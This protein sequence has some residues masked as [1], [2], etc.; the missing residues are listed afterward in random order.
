MESI[1]PQIKCFD[2]KQTFYRNEKDIMEEMLRRPNVDLEI[3][4]VKCNIRRC[5]QSYCGYIIDKDFTKGINYET[6]NYRVHGGFTSRWGFDCCH[7]MLGD[8]SILP[9]FNQVNNITESSTFKTFEF[10]R[11]E[12]EKLIRHMKGL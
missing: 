10:V 9:E 8:I 11:Y 6:I 1:T 12:L 2:G 7:Y 5:S 3:L 4:G